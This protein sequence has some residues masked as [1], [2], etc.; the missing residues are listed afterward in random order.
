MMI[1]M[2]FFDKSYNST[3]VNALKQL[4]NRREREKL[5]TGIL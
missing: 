2:C 5:F 4:L 3:T 1:K